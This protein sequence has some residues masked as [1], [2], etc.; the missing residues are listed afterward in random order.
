M[1]QDRVENHAEIVACMGASSLQI[2]HEHSI[3]THFVHLQT[4]MR[5]DTMGTVTGIAAMGMLQVGTGPLV[6]Q[7]PMHVQSQGCKWQMAVICLE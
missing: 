1:C 6:Q 4:G 2:A 3:D 5:M 7:P